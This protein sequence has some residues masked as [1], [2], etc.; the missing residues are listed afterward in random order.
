MNITTDGNGYKTYEFEKGEGLSV[1]TFYDNNPY[2]N[3]NHEDEDYLE[4]YWERGDNDI[5]GYLGEKYRGQFITLYCYR[6]LKFGEDCDYES[7]G[8]IGTR[9]YIAMDGESIINPC[10]S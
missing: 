4:E 9:Y 5:M 1:T 3:E 10:D 8:S 6:Y 7:G 2:E